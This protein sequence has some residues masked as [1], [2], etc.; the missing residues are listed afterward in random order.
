M[1]TEVSLEQPENAE[2]PMLFPLVMTTVCKLVLGRYG[3][4]RVGTVSFAREIHPLNAD[5]PMLVTL[6]GM[7]TE[8]SPVHPENAE[9]PMLVTLSGMIREVSP[10]Q[11]R[12]A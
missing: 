10:E 3:I 6:S 12:N 11:L 8:V 5:D 2:V 7:V 9:D 1:V 4:A